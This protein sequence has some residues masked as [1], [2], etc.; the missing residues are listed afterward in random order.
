[1]LQHCGRNINCFLT[2]F[3]FPIS[4]QLIPP[5]LKRAAQ[6][7]LVTFIHLLIGSH[8]LCELAVYFLNAFGRDWGA[9]EYLGLA[10]LP[11]TPTIVIPCS[12]ARFCSRVLSEKGTVV[13]ASAVD[14]EEIL[15]KKVLL[16]PCARV[17]LYLSQASITLFRVWLF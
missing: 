5:R 14:K 9:L 16:G 3:S 8:R 1:V 12:R 10:P 17:R 13:S 15:Y 6:A 11:L 2:A 7:I 4:H